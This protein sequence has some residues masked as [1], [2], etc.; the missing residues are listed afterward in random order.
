MKR[1]TWIA[2]FALAFGVA[3]AAQALE[4]TAAVKVTPLVKSTTSWNG[5]RVAYP[6]GEAEITG[7]VIEI[8]PGAETGWHAH[9]V[10]SFGMV[11]QGTLE[12]S[13]KDGRRKRIGAGEGLIEVVDTL[14]N[15]RNVGTEPVKI[16][17]FYAGAVGMPLTVK[18]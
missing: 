2:A 1:F 16:V 3:V 15:G 4:E 17:V 18:P 10:P 13:L 8:A 7:M 9:P 12:V 11:L 6:R 14:H 5:K